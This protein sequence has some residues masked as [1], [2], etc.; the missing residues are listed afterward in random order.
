M[1]IED[2]QFLP[3][4]DGSWKL[5]ENMIPLDSWTASLPKASLS[6]KSEQTMTRQKPSETN[7]E[8][9][10]L[11]ALNLITDAAVRSLMQ[12]NDVYKAFTQWQESVGDKWKPLVQSLAS[13]DRNPKLT[14]P[15]GRLD[16]ELGT[17]KLP[18][19]QTALRVEEPLESSEPWKVKLCLSDRLHPTYIVDMVDL[20]KGEHPWRVNPISQLKSDAHMISKTIPYL[21]E[22]GLSHAEIE[23]HADD[24][25]T[26]CT[27][28]NEQLKELGVHLIVP[29]WL[30]QRKQL[31]VNLAI[32]TPKQNNA[33]SEPLLNW[34][35]VANF[36]YNIAIGD[37]VLS[38]EDFTQY[39]EEKR[40]FIY[41]N[42]Q[43]IAWDPSM[44]KKL[45]SYLEHLDQKATYLDTLLLDELD[46]DQ[47]QTGLDVDWEVEWQ[48]EM[49]DSLTKIYQ[50]EPPLV[51]L[52][53]LFTGELRAYQHQGVSWLAHL[54][55]AGFGGVLADDMGLGKSIQT[56]VYMLYVKDAQKKANESSEPFLLICPTSLLYNWAHEAKQFAPSLRVF[57]HHGQTRIT[58]LLDSDELDQW[59]VVLTSYQL[60]VR[61]AEAFKTIQWN[62]MVLDEAQHIKNVD[63]K[64]RRVIKQFRANHIFALTGTPIENRLRELW[65]LM[66][67]TNPS[68]LGRYSAFQNQFIKKIE[69]EKDQQRL[70]QLQATIRPFVLRRK[71]ND[72]S[73]QLNLPEKRE[74]IHNVH[75]SLEQAAYYQAVVEEVSKQLNEVSNMERRSLILRSLTRLKQICNHPAHF[76]K[77][78]DMDAHESGKWTEFVRIVDE[79][80]ANNEKVLIF[81]QYKEMGSLITQELEKRYS[82]PVPFLHGS[83]TRAMR[84]AVITDFQTNEETTAFVLSLKAGGV[85]LNLTAATHVIHY[86]RWWNPA[87]EN[88]A[89]DRAFRIGQTSDVTV[90]KLITTGT[91]EERI[92]RMLV[93]KQSLADEILSSDAAKFTEMTNDEVLNLIRLTKD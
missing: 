51:H 75:L 23:L 61:D 65:S 47:D 69:K 40:P 14:Q 41:Q 5:K 84:Q 55:R 33:Y 80:Q 70:E 25:F 9:Q 62:G 4:A 27:N 50:E 38:S 16:Q 32:D 34:E 20:E 54:R 52:P 73:L 28:F 87:V 43:W 64:Q 19:F 7:Y 22:I 60:A 90:H 77:T 42:G 31:S 8:N 71:K 6:L 45:Q 68:L 53:Q 12:N 76:L 13:S 58:Q 85:G 91:V 37:V 48:E 26:L 86:D 82:R 30:K 83:L 57:I 59:D 74:R 17:V 56:L 66:D 63:T 10:V 93:T 78:K 3:A 18:P 39:V 11:N 21:N 92:D 36:T 44:A 89:T 2:G 35:N 24:V 29:N 81:T 15:T 1:M 67:V 79:I 49:K 72:L 46:A 88:Q